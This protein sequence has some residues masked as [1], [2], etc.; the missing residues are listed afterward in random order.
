MSSRSRDFHIW[1]AL[2]SVPIG[3]V[4]FEWSA[5]FSRTHGADPEDGVWRKRLFALAITDTL[6][7]VLAALALFSASDRGG[8]A[9]DRVITAP[10]QL[11]V[12]RDTATSTV[13]VCFSRPV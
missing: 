8:S 12:Y 1:L 5:M 10:G 2:G 6:I 4:L 9:F 11:G 13:A 3:A 7:A